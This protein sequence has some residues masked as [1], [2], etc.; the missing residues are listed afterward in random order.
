MTSPVEIL[1][2]VAK[3]QFVSE[4]NCNVCLH[5]Q[6]IRESCGHIIERCHHPKLNVDDEY[7]EVDGTMICNWYEA[8]YP[9]R[10]DQ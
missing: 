9:T 2:E 3:Q 7:P 1:I 8:R 5:C 6:S 10:S 4:D